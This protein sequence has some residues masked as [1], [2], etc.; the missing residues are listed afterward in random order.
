MKDVIEK[1]TLEINFDSE[2]K[3]KESLPLLEKSLTNLE[4]FLEIPSTSEI[5]IIPEIKIH[6]KDLPEGEFV[7]ILER[8][9]SKKIIAE[10][11]KNAGPSNSTKEKNQK[12]SQNI[13]QILRKNPSYLLDYVLDLLQNKGRSKREVQKEIIRLINLGS[14][15]DL[16]LEFAFEILPLLNSQVRQ[17]DFSFYHQIFWQLQKI[18]IPSQP[19]Q[20][21]YFK[22]LFHAMHK[23][24]I[25]FIN[26]L[27]SE[28]VALDFSVRNEFY[29]LFVQQ[30]VFHSTPLSFLEEFFQL[31][32]IGKSREQ[33]EANIHLEN[34]IAG[35]FKYYLSSKIFQSYSFRKKF[36]D[37]DTLIELLSF[38]NALLLRKIT[39][40]VAK[41]KSNRI[42]IVKMLSDKSFKI[43][44]N[45]VHKNFGDILFQIIDFFQ[46]I[47]NQIVESNQD[48]I[49]LKNTIKEISLEIAIKQERTGLL[50]ETFL[51][52]TIEF[53]SS[54]N[55]I[56]KKLIYLEIRK[57]L[58]STKILNSRL[59]TFMSV[60]LDDK[61]KKDPKFDELIS[62]TISN[63]AEPTVIGR[64]ERNISEKLNPKA[65]QSPSKMLGD[66]LEIYK[67]NG[68]NI[69]NTIQLYFKLDRLSYNQF[70]KVL[71]FPPSLQKKKTTHYF[72][73]ELA[74]FIKERKKDTIQSIDFYRIK[75]L[76]KQHKK[77]IKTFFS[78]LGNLSIINVFLS[79]Y[80]YLQSNQA[81][82]WLNT[83]DQKTKE[84]VIQQARPKLLD[85]LIDSLTKRG[86]LKIKT[87]TLVE[88]KARISSFLL[89]EIAKGTDD[90]NILDSTLDLLIEN[91]LFL[92][93]LK[94]ND[95]IS[96]SEIRFSTYRNL[97]HYFFASE[98][99]FPFWLERA[100]HSAETIVQAIGELIQ[101]DPKSLA[102]NI[103]SIPQSQ[104]AAK[105]IYSLFENDLLFPLLKIID[106]SKKTQLHFIAEFALKDKTKSKATMGKIIPFLNEEL[107]YKKGFNFQHLKEFSS[108]VMNLERNEKNVFYFINSL[109]S[110]RNQAELVTI[111]A[112]LKK[113]EKRKILNIS[114][115][116]KE[117]I[118]INLPLD[119]QIKL[120]VA[121]V[122]DPKIKSIIER[123]LPRDTKTLNL[124]SNLIFRPGALSKTDLQ[125]LE[126][127]FDL[128]NK[129]M[130]SLFFEYFNRIAET[131]KSY[132]RS[133][134]P[135]DIIRSQ[136]ESNNGKNIFE[137]TNFRKAI[138][139]S[140]PKDIAQ[141]LKAHQEA[142]ILPQVKKMVSHETFGEIMLHFLAIKS[143][144]ENQL[145]LDI[146]KQIIKVVKP[147]KEYPF[148][149]DQFYNL[150][151][152]QKQNL[153][154]AIE[155]SLQS[156]QKRNQKLAATINE[157]ISEARA[158]ED[159][160]INEKMSSALEYLIKYNSL[161]K[162]QNYTKKQLRAF[163]SK[164]I[165]NGGK[166]VR[167]LL[168][169]LIQNQTY[170]DRIT[171]LIGNMKPENILY[172]VHPKLPKIH[173][174][175]FQLAK[176]MNAENKALAQLNNKSMHKDLLMLWGKF[177]LNLQ[178]PM[179][180]YA[181]ML[182]K[183]N[184][185]LQ[186]FFLDRHNLE[187]LNKTE[188]EW[189]QK[190]FDKSANLPSKKSEEKLKQNEENIV[191]YSS[192]LVLLWPFLGQFFSRLG[193]M[194][195]GVF[196]DIQAQEKACKFLEFIASNQT[197]FE[198][199]KMTTSKI[200][201]GLDVDYEILNNSL[202]LSKTDKKICLSL[203]KG[204]LQNWEKNNNSSIENFQA[205]FLLRS[206]IFSEKSNSFELIM[207]KKPYDVLLNSLPWKINQII[208]RWMKKQLN[209]YWI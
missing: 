136:I 126:K 13:E 28:I 24:K 168:W 19:I 138:D 77:L 183:N 129:K 7:K 9:L 166:D 34:L 163:L 41:S 63:Q 184:P 15:K 101:F 1:I 33:V 6:L 202:E 113:I 20:I 5:I 171:K 3:A 117:N 81:T 95:P 107:R 78:Y 197:S 38:K 90:K 121:F 149:I 112:N 86:H 93:A 209:V 108:E 98:G 97:V 123:K 142:K 206:A 65:H 205:S 124:I 22:S 119:D 190:L 111:A 141:F 59:K 56:D 174:D 16:P 89:L 106:K 125:T 91:N 155:Q 2:K 8:E 170:A 94:R 69:F 68:E 116:F 72:L 45:N 193:L 161:S 162:S 44:L 180:L 76:P 23:S 88:I 120:L 134:K 135:L 87:S 130:I 204:V 158:F 57:S 31:F 153:E 80:N 157:V 67:F 159:F 49:A 203:Q 165:E 143:P 103:D 84:K 187:K 39:F 195:K 52:R 50:S 127:R 27:Y 150:Y 182:R 32:R 145:L 147:L 198:N 175:I 96:S 62:L 148:F 40:S 200:L 176:K 55:S 29:Q 188:A 83:F 154:S 17:K 144:L 75:K 47:D 160:T 100:A 199:E 137:H 26:L 173:K 71:D 60:Y 185:K 156:V 10:V 186:D 192:G 208:L 11:Q 92:P 74:I 21:Y 189:V 104:N 25:D 48:N 102:Q 133:D 37:I 152:V 196:H 42:K 140:T 115:N 118:R 181:Q 177:S 122:E 131:Q 66:G 53:Y 79:D 114:K 179:K 73:N 64:K 58:W 54:K 172:F 139:R 151:F 36:S 51:D 167:L 191:F 110:A 164:S 70:L 18:S 128:R 85:S 43:L 4:T 109:F 207:D 14:I 35:E 194:E 146:F 169:K 105:L 46:K 82:R 178:D 61:Q 99:S 12:L 30:Q 132:K 201:C